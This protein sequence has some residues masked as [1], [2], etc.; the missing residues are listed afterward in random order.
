MKCSYTEQYER[1]L[2]IQHW[3]KQVRNTRLRTVWVHLYT[4]Q[5]LINSIRDTY[6]DGKQK[7]SW[8]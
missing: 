8:E 7:E 5:E 3:I 1:I 6:M 2:Q 4:L